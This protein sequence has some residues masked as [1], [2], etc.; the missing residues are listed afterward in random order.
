MGKRKK[1]APNIFE[2]FEVGN[3]VSKKEYGEVV[4]Q[5]RMDLLNMQYDLK[6]CDF[7]VLI[8]IAGNNRKAANEVLDIFH[9][10]MDVRYLNT[11]VFFAPKQDELE[12]PTYWRYWKAMPPSGRIGIFMAGWTIRALAERVLEDGSDEMLEIQVEHMKALEKC[13]VDN[14][15]LLIKLWLHVPKDEVKKD[16]KS[17]KKDPDSEPYIRQRDWDIYEKYSR[18]I[19]Y[20]SNVITET[21]TREAPWEIIESS[22]KAFRNLR[23]FRTI[24]DA[25]RKQIDAPRA[26]RKDNYLF[27]ERVSKGALDKVDLN[28][29]LDNKEYSKQLEDLQAIINRLTIRARDKFATVLMFEGW[30]AAG[31][32]GVIRRITKAM[33]PEDYRVISI[34]APTPEEKKHH[35]LWRFWRHIPRDGEMVIFDRSWYGRVLVERVEGFA[36]ER[37]WQN[38][39]YEIND[40]EKQLVEHGIVLCKFWVHIDS[41]EQLR[42]FKA[43]EKTGYK[44]YKITDEDYRNREKWDQYTIAV[45]DMVERTSTTEAPWNLVSANDKK[46]AR[47]RV[48]ETVTKALIE[49]LKE[50]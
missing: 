31:K 3:K 6:D 25:I 15:T 49:R 39:Y 41:D 1:R 37:E 22:N 46:W 42:R 4:P 10:W 14:N 20:A 18:I 40:F 8:L 32:G 48:L 19:T 30:D 36:T 35:Y 26:Q 12:H 50:Y 43:R 45:N 21:S 7:Q 29:S 23:V 2:S 24:L 5:L 11:H 16:L 27:P 47:V 33:F 9:E 44:K 38:A 28:R 34:A 17:A 13:L